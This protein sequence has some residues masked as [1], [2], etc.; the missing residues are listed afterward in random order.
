MSGVAAHE[1]KTLRD[2]TGVGMMEAKA[3]LSE[4]AGDLDRAI[5]ILR[6]KGQL[7]AQKRLTRQTS[8]GT[9]EAYIHGE[10]RI[11]VLLEVNCET[12]FVARN[13]EFKSLT[14]NLALHVA[15]QAPL[16][17]S[18]EDVPPEVLHKEQEIYLDESR[19]AGKPAAI[20]EK[21]AAGRLEKFFEETCLLDQPFVRDPDITVQ[22][23]I[24]QKIAVIGENIKV[25][26]FAR[27]VLGE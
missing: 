13:Q 16:Y 11:G 27:F 23:L 1:V 24:N 6:R 14:H 20:A 10:G 17:V 9:V 3:A 22:E 18:R 21:I 25:K 2:K 26:R 12:D 15:A 5:E 4:A 7:K 8:A 19:G